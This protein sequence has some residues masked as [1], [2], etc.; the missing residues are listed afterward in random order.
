M[1]LRSSGVDGAA[2][3]TTRQVPL[4]SNNGNA[5]LDGSGINGVDLQAAPEGLASLM[6]GDTHAR[7]ARHQ[8]TGASAAAT[9]I[10][11][12]V[13]AT[14]LEAYAKANTSGGVGGG[15]G[16]G[17]HA[18]QTLA[19]RGL[20]LFP[21]AQGGGGVASSS[22]GMED[23]AFIPSFSLLPLAPTN[24][25]MPP[26]LTVLSNLDADTSNVE[27]RRG[28][29]ARSGLEQSSSL[30]GS[31]QDMMGLPL[32]FPGFALHFPTD[33]APS[34]MSVGGGDL[35]QLTSFLGNNAS[36]EISIIRTAWTPSMS[37]VRRLRTRG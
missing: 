10:P 11:T 22:P 29:I 28:D 26:M 16:E 24:E 13:A 15:G 3:G 37:C 18:T 6:V 27:K 23:S 17:T 14:A 34:A 7:M 30:P 19:Y 5:G 21:S 25:V 20:D 9:I 36:V 12:T 1:T 35:N 4:F 31:A 33:H 8:P 2:P 32:L